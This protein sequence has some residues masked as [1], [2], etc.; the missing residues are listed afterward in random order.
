RSGYARRA[1]S[2]DWRYAWALASSFVAGDSASFRSTPCARACGSKCSLAAAVDRSTSK[3]PSVSAEPRSRSAPRSP[4]HPCSSDMMVGGS[5]PPAK[6]L[7]SGRPA[8]PG[9]DVLSPAPQSPAAVRTAL[10]FSAQDVLGR[11]VLERELRVHA[12]EFRVLCLKFSHALELRDCNPG[13]LRFPVV[14]GRRTDAVLA[15]DLGDRYASFA[16]LQDRNDLRLCV[17]RS[18]EHTSELQ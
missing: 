13:V 6:A 8:R 5:T 2:A 9:A 10:Q 16:F 1:P 7:R 4:Q 14:V 12:L 17:F 11:R 15:H 18:E 3:S